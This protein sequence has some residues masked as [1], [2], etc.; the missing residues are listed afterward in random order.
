MI[1]C[2]FCGSSCYKE[3]KEDGEEK[4]WHYITNDGQISCSLCV[5]HI[6]VECG[7]KAVFRQQSMRPDI[8]YLACVNH[9]GNTK[10]ICQGKVT[11]KRRNQAFY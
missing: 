9:G 7:E 11:Q 5:E 3:C 6:C 10:F 2:D 4:Q 8:K 1:I